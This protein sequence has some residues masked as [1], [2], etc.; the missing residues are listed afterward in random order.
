VKG[1]MPFK[2]KILLEISAPLP[3]LQDIKLDGHSFEFSFVR[4]S[5][6]F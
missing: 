5:I 4:L 6:L 2:V 3:N 1:N